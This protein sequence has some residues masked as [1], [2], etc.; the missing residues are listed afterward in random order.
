MNEGDGMLIRQAYEMD[1]CMIFRAIIM[2]E[3]RYY[4]I[5]IDYTDANKKNEIAEKARG[6]NKIKEEQ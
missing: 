6:S 4:N 1:T 2:R 5:Y 3:R